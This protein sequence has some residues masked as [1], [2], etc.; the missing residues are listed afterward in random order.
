MEIPFSRTLFTAP[1]FVD[2]GVVCASDGAEDDMQRVLLRRSGEG[3]WAGSVVLVEHVVFGRRTALAAALQRDERFNSALH[4]R[5]SPDRIDEKIDNNAFLGLDATYRLGPGVTRFNHA[6][7]P[8][9]V[10]RYVYEET[11]RKYAQGGIRKD[12]FAIV[13]ACKDIEP[14]QEIC[15]QYNPEHS[16]TLFACGCGLSPARRQQI[17]DTNARELGPIIFE[18]NRPFLEN[19]IAQYLNERDANRCPT[20]MQIASVRIGT[21]ATCMFAGFIRGN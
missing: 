1:V 11:P 8:N 16:H 3:M 7:D 4:P 17:Q 15:Y 9:A 2:A 21:R 19:L 10:V 5:S 18:K 12:G 14:G 20:A 6:C 13:Y